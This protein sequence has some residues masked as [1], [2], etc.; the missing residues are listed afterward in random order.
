MNK[1]RLDVLLVQ[2]GLASTREKARAYIMAGEIWVNGQRAEKA[3]SQ[4]EIN[5]EF[6]HRSTRMDYVGRGGYKLEGA[7]HAF[8]LNFSNQV[9]L[10]VGASTGGY[11]DYALQHG[12]KKVY[13]VDVGYGQLDWSLRNRPE[14]VVRERVN[15][16]YLTP[17]MFDEA[18]DIV[19]MDVSFI[20]VTLI[21]PALVPLLTPDGEIVTLIKPQFESSKAQVGKKGI[22]RDPVVH[23]M[24]LERCIEA[25]KDLGLFPIGCCYSP[26]KGTKGNIEFF[27]HLTRSFDYGEGD[28]KQDI[29]ALVRK[30]HQELED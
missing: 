28:L 16:R 24:V 5:A 9:V 23:Q 15:A 18:I 7:A 1:M 19:V 27:L 22:V 20:S 11:T 6:E 29:S 21:F 30:A 13:A 26:I 8:D 14:V 4:V 12:A 17:D 2:K 25:A 10:D 3:G